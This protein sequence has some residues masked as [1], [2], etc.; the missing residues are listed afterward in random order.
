VTDKD[1]MDLEKIVEKHRVFDNNVLLPEDDSE[2]HMKL[3]EISGNRMVIEFQRIILPV[4]YFIR[5][6]FNSFFDPFI[7]KTSRDEL[8][9]H[10]DLV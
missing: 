3:F 1:I 9:S 7:K 2:F 10:K 5:E 6:N 4:Y 8:V